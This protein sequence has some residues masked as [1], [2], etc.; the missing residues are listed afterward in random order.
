[1]K[2]AVGGKCHAKQRGG[3]VGFGLENLLEKDRLKDLGVDGRKIL[4]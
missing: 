2:D 4:T 1:M 3:V